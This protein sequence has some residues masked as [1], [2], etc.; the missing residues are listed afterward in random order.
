MTSLQTTRQAMNSLRRGAVLL[1][2]LAVAS[3]AQGAESISPA[4][5]LAWERRDF[6]DPTAYRLEEHA[7]QT[8]LQA[9]CRNAASALYLE[10]TIDLRETPVLEW[11]WT[12][13]DVFDN[14]DE[15]RK[16]GDDYPVRLYVVKDG[17]LLAWRTRAV[18]RP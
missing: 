12:V 3:T 13:A 14:T 10:T 7:G 11:S 1:C 15:T 8:L 2:V 6:A 5:I 17:G 9:Q 18:R 16:S 4:D